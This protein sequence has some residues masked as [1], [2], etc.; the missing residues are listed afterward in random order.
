MKFIY[1]SFPYLRGLQLSSSEASK[2][3]SVRS[4]FMVTLIHWR[5]SLHNICELLHFGLLFWQ[6]ISSE[7][8]PQSSRPLHV[9]FILVQFPLLQVNSSD[10][11]VLSPSGK[12]D[13][14]Q[15]V[16]NKPRITKFYGFAWPVIS[17]G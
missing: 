4:H 12:K 9:H 1:S 6:L 16:R 13:E 17:K 3:S 15:Q 10:L 7:E 5:S 11:H 8:S 14:R 2:Q